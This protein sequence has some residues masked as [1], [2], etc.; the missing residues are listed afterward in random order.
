MLHTIY[1][2]NE[3]PTRGGGRTAPHEQAREAEPDLAKRLDQGLIEKH[4]D[5]AKYHDSYRER[6][7]LA[8]GQKLGGNEPAADAPEPKRGA[9]D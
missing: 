2:T 6:V 4:F 1:Y 5:P 7:M 9:G 8:A 3:S